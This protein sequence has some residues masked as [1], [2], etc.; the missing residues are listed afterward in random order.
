MLTHAAKTTAA[1]LGGSV[2][3]E[4]TLENLFNQAA[5]PAKIRNDSFFLKVRFLA[6]T[7]QEK[8]NPISIVCFCV[9]GLRYREQSDGKGHHQSVCRSGCFRPQTSPDAMRLATVGAYGGDQVS[10]I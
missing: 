3:E 2:A 9:C 8:Q 7:K 1:A 10:I 6:F 4:P 5:N